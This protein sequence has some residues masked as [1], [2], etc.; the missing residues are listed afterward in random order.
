MNDGHV[1]YVHIFGALGYI[2]DGITFDSDTKQQ[3]SLAQHGVFARTFNG[4]ICAACK[5]KNL[6]QQK[7]YTLHSVFV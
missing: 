7:K 5:Q 3:V 1:V 4:Y 2:C 6:Q